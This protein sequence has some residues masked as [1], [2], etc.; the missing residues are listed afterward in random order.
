MAKDTTKNKT[1]TLWDH[2]NAVTKYQ[3]KNYW[4]SL[5]ESDRKT[6][7]TYMICRFLSMNEE[8]VDI[9][10]EIQ[11]I[12]QGLEPKLV[13]QVLIG[14]IPKSKKY[15]KYVKGTKELQNEEWLVDLVKKTY[16]VGNYQAN[17]YIKILGSTE[18]GRQ[19]IVDICEMYGTDP[20]KIKKLKLNG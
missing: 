18:I 11:P 6:W 3:K 20:K 9:V 16:E 2:L 7:S 4:E 5:T 13:Y 8:W 1:K 12:V 10:N 15:L 17:T 14:I 19:T